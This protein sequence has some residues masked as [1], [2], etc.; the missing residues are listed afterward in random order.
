MSYYPLA[1]LTLDDSLLGFRKVAGNDSVGMYQFTVQSIVA[2]LSGLPPQSGHA[3][4]ALF[5]DG[6][7]PGWAAVVASFNG[8]S[9]AVVPANGDYTVGQVTGAV[10][11]TRTITAGTGLTGGGDLTANR[12]LGLAN[13][14]SAGTYTKV[15][16]DAQG[17]VSSGTTLV[18]AD[19]PS[20]V[21]LN[22]GSYGD[23]SWLTSLAAAKLT[24]T[25]PAGRFPAISGDI[26]ITAGTVV[27][28]LATVN[29]NVGTFNNV[30]V[31]AKGLVTSASTIAYIT[32]ASTDVLTNKSYDAQG[33][34]NII[35]NLAVTNFAANVVDDDSLLAANSSTR[36]PTQR[37]AK[38]Y[39][40]NLLTGLSWKQSV[41]AATTTNGTLATAFANG[42]TVDG[43]ALA[44]GDRVLL[45]NQTTGS[46]N[47]IYTVNTSGAPTRATDADTN[48]EVPGATV[49]VREGTINADTQWTCTNDTVTLG[50]TSVTFAQVSGAGTYSAGAGL[51]LIGNQF[52]VDGT[53]VT[54]A[55]T[56][57][58]TNKSIAATQLTG[59]LAAAQ[60][61]ALTGHVITTAGNLATTIQ[62][63]VVTN[64]ML[65][66]AIAAA[67]L[68]GSDIATVGTVTGGTWNATPIGLAYG[69][70]GQ[71]TAAASFDA[72][73]G[74]TALG[75]L[76]Y[77]G[78]AGT[79]TRLAGNTTTT[80][81]FLRQT[82]DGTNSTAPA[83]DIFQVG[84]VPVL[85]LST[86]SF[87]GTLAAG[88]FPALTG[89]LT[90]VAGGLA[91]T[92]ATVNSNVGTFNNVTVNGKGLVTA[93]SSIAYITASS[94]DTLTNKSYDA[95]GAG[96]NLTN[97]TT[98]HFA[99]NVID[100]DSSFAAN[101]ATRLPTQRA[102]KS[103]V[104]NLLTGLSWKQSVRAA[105][106][107]N[108]TL[109]TAFANGQVVDGVTLATGDRILLKNQATG[110]QNGIYVVAASGAPTRATD[111]D[112]N[113]E[114]P[115]A[116]V[117]VREGTTN[118]D[119]QWTCTN[120]AITLGTTSVVFVQV[121]GA[122]TYSGGTGI[123]LTGNQ[124]SADTSVVATLTGI[125]TLTNK[126]IAATQLTGTLAA[127]QF[128]ALT[129]NVT[130]VAGGL[131]T[132]IGAG[133]VTN[134]ML[135]GSI[136]AAKL[137][138]S[139]IV[140][141]GIV[142]TGTWNASVIGPAYGGTGVANN[143]ASTL[144]IS[145]NYAM[146]LTVT[147][148]TGLTLPITG[149]LTTLAG[150]ETLT[151]K[152]LTAPTI[153]GG[154]H[155]GLTGLAVRDTSTAFD[156]T[157]AATSST[158]LT[159]ART[160]TLDVVDGARTM[161][162]GGN[163]TLAANFVTIG[164]N[165]LTLTTT[166]TTNVTLPT[167][168][169]LAILGANTFT[170]GQTI[171]AGAAG[172]V[173]LIVKGAASQT[174]NLQQWQN[175]AGTSLLGVGKQGYLY[176]DINLLL[177]W[178]GGSND[179]IFVGIASGNSTVTATA[180]VGIGQG[181]LAALTSGNRNIGVGV[182]SLAACQT[183]MN[184]TAVGGG[185]VL[186]N[187]TGSGCTG[188]GDLAGYDNMSGSFNTYIGELAGYTGSTGVHNYRTA[189]GYNAQP[190]ADHEIRLGTVNEYVQCPGSL[191][192]G[193]AALATSATDGFLNIP[194]CA[195]KPTG[196]PTTYAGTAALVGNSADASLN[197]Y[198]GGKWRK[199]VSNTTFGP[200][201][202][203]KT[204]PNDTTPYAAND[205]ICESS[206]AGTVWTFS[207]IAA[208]SGGSGT[209]LTAHVECSNT[210]NV[211]RFE[212]DLY[213]TAPTAIND[214]AEA[215]RLTGNV[216]S[217]VGTVTFPA[218]VKKTANSTVAEANADVKIP[219]L[220]SGSANLFGIVRTLD[221]F[222][223][224]ASSTYDV[225]F[226]GIQ[227]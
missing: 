157:V 78:A 190:A 189:L 214:N 31:N 166:G 53:V 184:N 174:A 207:N 71:T 38:S 111:A 139:D 13:L 191:V 172:T 159:A 30:T 142:G 125:Q 113:A 67:K 109:A 208:Y 115:T 70:T 203:R 150:V 29:S 135:A 10:P 162:L 196:V 194:Y 96:N 15:T 76:V 42:Q 209:I 126:S 23:P 40:D 55:G 227:D 32:S 35:T 50:T 77:G 63:G 22:T 112:T 127:A 80:R 155:V 24:G 106:T 83:W 193:T 167:A 210:A 138:G 57:I 85:D 8:R 123:T 108:G 152:T 221:A 218:L 151:N 82:G 41:R 43:V 211:A 120:D 34:G 17:R 169:T 88:R 163:L 47:G 54:L 205:C 26:S 131:A 107:A 14:G 195:G 130:T 100:D 37:A 173:G 225:N 49:F 136:A 6:M 84:D 179:N 44:T 64:A 60:F 202:T 68:V 226:S 46:Q 7:V 19:L 149:T 79:R 87:T 5:T 116:T 219:F 129:G 118:A 90:T 153:S 147:G 223:P 213:T 98:T 176:Q 81:K 137:V 3:G 212:V 168:G 224:T 28:T 94:T 182:S 165:S 158:A 99:A 51:S 103:Y 18:A 74:M 220:T 121:A 198:I 199:F 9:G 181:S 171:G 97:L 180:V 1:E 175:S 72:L 144:A 58:L 154:T 93:A 56:Q 187:T 2:T 86:G 160:F 11:D 156:V 95:Q 39:V 52:G 114:L 134:A 20:E 69:G 132:T 75:D 217:Y 145:G 66:G 92:L 183:G 148:I 59:T 4:Q 25:L 73:S 122:G 201:N 104:D 61:P 206:S 105:T 185:L 141:V 215:T 89:D 101:S 124:F 197:L 16:T 117:F 110:S 91:T 21:I 216:A 146:T 48:A 204:R 133:V 186:G 140:T 33:T 12:T 27:A 143:A 200:L 222:T 164:A 188:V 65:A 170:A 177:H 36:I 119:T 178:T 102:A 62:P 161:K 45:K 128:P 192:V